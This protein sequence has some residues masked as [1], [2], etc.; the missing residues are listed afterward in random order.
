MAVIK[1]PKTP[2]KA[3]NTQRRPSALLLDQIK[4]LEWAVLP[5][6][7]R[8]PGQLP[9]RKVKTEGQAAERIGQLTQMLLTQAEQAY[10]PGV[11]VAE[12]PP[13]TLPPLPPATSKPGKSRKPRRRKQSRPKTRTK[14]SKAKRTRRRTR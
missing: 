3:F 5:A 6:S 8:K 12:R 9:R 10:E 2:K 14:A 7:Q 4:H 11:D 13:V 1:V